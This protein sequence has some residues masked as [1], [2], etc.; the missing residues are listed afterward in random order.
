MHLCFVKQLQ[1]ELSIHCLYSLLVG[2]HD[3]R[4]QSDRAQLA[5]AQ[6]ARARA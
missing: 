4:T 2:T 5:R 1:K 6:S 3:V